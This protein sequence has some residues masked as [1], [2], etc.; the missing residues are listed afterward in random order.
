MK[1]RLRKKLSKRFATASYCCGKEG[2]INVH[3]IRKPSRGFMRNHSQ[4]MV[5][6]WCGQPT[7]EEINNTLRRVFK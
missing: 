7:D 2:V 6:D 3:G 5:N 1:K 4:W